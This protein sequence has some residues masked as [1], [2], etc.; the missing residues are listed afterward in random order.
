MGVSFVRDDSN[1]LDSSGARQLGR[2]CSSPRAGFVRT[3]R[4]RVAGSAQL[5]YPE[6][7]RRSAQRLIQKEATMNCPRCNSAK[8]N[9]GSHK[10]AS[11]YHTFRC[12]ECKC[13]FN[14]RTGTPFNNLQ[15]PT[16]VVLL[17]VVWRL[18]YKLSLRDL[19]EMFLERGFDF[20]HEAVRDWEARFAPLITEQLRSRRKGNAGRSWYADETYI[21]VGGKWCYLYRA[22]DRD[23]NL[24]DSMLS[25]QRNTQAAKRFFT[26]A[27][28]V[29]G[30]KPARVTTDGHDSYP[31]AI[32]RI[33]GRKIEHRTNR[34]ALIKLPQQPAGTRSPGHQTEVLS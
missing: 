29:T 9:E 7:H 20:T 5:V 13:R 26:Q 19:A 25:E 12:S 33:L 18:R 28:E 17:V 23:G 1:E 24:V 34:L 8:T 2:R 30:H 32:R 15:F 11:G 31:R 10:T 21:K 6:D 22:I 16:D 14:E 27:G 3:Q 4:T